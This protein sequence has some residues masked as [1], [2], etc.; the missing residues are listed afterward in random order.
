[1]NPVTRAVKA[2]YNFVAG[3]DPIILVGVIIAFIVATV[4][5][6]AVHAPNVLTA[7]LFVACIVGSLTLTL[8]RERPV[9]KP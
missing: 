6:Q 7:V 1:M 8:A 4:L 3:G 5:A 2:T 9:R